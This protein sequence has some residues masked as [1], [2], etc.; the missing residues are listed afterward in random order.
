MPVKINW[1]SKEARIAIT[2]FITVAAIIIFSR[3]IDDIDDLLGVLSAAFSKAA[4]VLAPFVM[5]AIICYIL[6]PIVR[7]LD[8]KALKFIR[9]KNL[10][11]GIAVLITYVLLLAGVAWLISYLIPILV[12]NVTD[13]ASHLPGYLEKGEAFVVHLMEELPMV[14]IPAVEKAAEASI[15]RV[16]E[17][18]E[19]GVAKLGE[20]VPNMVLA[21][22]GYVKKLTGLVTDSFVAIITSIYLLMDVE[23]L[24]VSAK[25]LVVSA[26]GEKRSKV[27]LMFVHDADRIF[28]QYIRARILTSTLVF[29]LSFI[30]FTAYGVPYATLFSLVGGI[31]N[32]IP[33]YG[34]II[35]FLIIVP[36]VLLISPEM[37]LFAGIFVTVMQ[38]LEGYLIDPMIMGD[39]VDMRPIWVLLAVT[40]GGTFGLGGMVLA[41]PVAAFIGTQLSRFTASRVG[42][43]PEEVKTPLFKKKAKKS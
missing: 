19:G 29:I 11:R 5:G 6:L 41:V 26:M 31:T 16:S 32:I 42:P 37:A 30:G 18:I 20:A 23:R 27:A 43:K 39:S 25:R 15:A 10:R 36:L 22:P 38:Q 4:T 17:L 9:F 33:F 13:F 21:L 8:R 12:S 3:V 1:K 7:F 14:G 28:G 40:V 34:P 2:V 35:G 24:K